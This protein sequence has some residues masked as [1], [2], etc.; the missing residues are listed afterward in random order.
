MANLCRAVDM[1]EDYSFAYVMF[2]ENCGHEPQ[3]SLCVCTER[4]VRFKCLSSRAQF[5]VQ[6]FVQWDKDS[7]KVRNIYQIMS[8][9]PTI[10]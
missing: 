5:F 1:R 2:K 4:K 6:N 7:A 9:T 8:S 10:V 3:V